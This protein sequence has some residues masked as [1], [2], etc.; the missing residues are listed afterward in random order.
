MLRLHNR[1]NSAARME[2]ADHFHPTRFAG[3][4]KIVENFIDRRFE[5]DTLVAKREVVI[6]QRLQLDA[7]FVRDV[8]N[9]DRRKI[10]KTRLRAYRREFWIDMRDLIVTVWEFVREG[11]DGVFHNMISTIGFIREDH[12]GS[13][14]VAAVNYNLV[15]LLRAFLRVALFRC[16]GAWLPS[17]FIICRLRVLR[18]YK[19]YS[20]RHRMPDE[21]VHLQLHSD[22]QSITQ[23]PRSQLSIIHHTE[24]R[25]K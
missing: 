5:K 21:L 6:L 14:I 25:R 15:N 7:Y 19:L 10:R 2:F 18:G 12:E 1:V 17:E 20:P 4:H 9:G 11:F 13:R 8:A 16:E 24:D 3:G 23:N 22:L